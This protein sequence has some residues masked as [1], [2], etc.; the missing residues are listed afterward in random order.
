M[1][2]DIVL[3]NM[4]WAPPT[5]PSLGLGIL[6]SC[7]E[8]E[9]FKVKVLHTSPKL[10]KWITIETYAFIAECWGIDEFLFTALLDPDCDDKQL[11][12]L[13]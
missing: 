4:P 10:L 3:V 8:L 7:L 13:V 6:K 11:N 9:G 12:A 1:Q 2:K 5:E